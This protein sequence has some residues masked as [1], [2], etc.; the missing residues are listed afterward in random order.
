MILFIIVFCSVTFIPAF[1]LSFTKLP[2]WV[3]WIPALFALAA[4]AYYSTRESFPQDSMFLLGSQNVWKGIFYLWFYLPGGI[5]GAIA[6]HVR[7][8]NR[9]IKERDEAKEQATDEETDSTEL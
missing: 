3:L 8:E 7:R 9:R 6:G 1:L 2:G 5:V 4:G